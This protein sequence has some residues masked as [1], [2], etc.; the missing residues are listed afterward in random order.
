MLGALLVLAAVV[1]GCGSSG[2]MTAAD[3]KAQAIKFAADMQT[4]GTSGPSSEAMAKL[5]STDPAERAT[6]KA[7]WDE[8]V[9][10]TKAAMA[11]IRALRP[12]AEYQ[13][14]HDRLLKGVAA[15]DK[16]LVLFDALIQKV[17]SGELTAAN[18]M[19]SPEY[20]AVMAIGNDTTL[21]ADSKGFTDAM[22]ELNAAK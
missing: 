22:S 20:T 15:S 14:I 16:L 6:A 1:A 9:K 10:Q 17:A 18:I 2:P 3:Y 12:P 19:T 11:G 13:S 21:A 4:A 7:A 8:A 5:T